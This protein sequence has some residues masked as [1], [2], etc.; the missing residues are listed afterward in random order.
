MLPT[1]TGVEDDPH[2]FPFSID[3]VDKAPCAFRFSEG[4]FTSVMLFGIRRIGVSTG[5]PGR[6]R[7][8]DHIA[9]L[10]FEFWG[11]THPVYLGQWHREV[12]SLSVKEGERVCSFTFW[13][14][15][16]SLPHNNSR[17]NQGRITGI[18]ITKT[19]LGQRDMEIILGD[20]KD[21]LSYSFT[22][23]PYE[24]LVRIPEPRRRMD[25]IL[26]F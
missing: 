8:L 7:G 20:K 1:D 10:C 6:T 5:L 3:V 16:E 4:C 23:N 19:G 2:S 25:S 14:Q 17:E 21:M 22:E 15:Q 18:R 12:G 11:S 26:T 13:Q 9:G 24:R